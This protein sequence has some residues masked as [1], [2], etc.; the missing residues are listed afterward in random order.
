M[1]HRP[2]LPDSC[3]FAAGNTLLRRAA[4]LDNLVEVVVYVRLADLVNHAVS[5]SLHQ[6]SRE[7][8]TTTN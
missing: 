3:D 4:K 1:G 5:T 8:D 2:A 6:Q 7:Q